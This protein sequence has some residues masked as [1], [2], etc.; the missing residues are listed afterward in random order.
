MKQIELFACVEIHD[1][2]ERKEFLSTLS[3]YGIDPKF[4]A[5][6]IEFR[7]VGSMGVISRLVSLCDAQKAHSIHVSA[8]G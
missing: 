1:R 6:K 3:V 8:V 2:L 5:D 4:L 7:C